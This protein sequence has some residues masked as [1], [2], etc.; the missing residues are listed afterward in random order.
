LALLIRIANISTTILKRIGDKWSPCQ[1]PFFVWKFWPTA[2]LIFIPTW[3]P[4]IKDA[5]HL[6][7]VGEK[8]FI[9]KVCYTKDQLILSYVFS[10]SI[11][12]MM[13]FYFFLCI[14]C[15]VSCNTITPSMM[16]LPGIKVVCDG[17]IVFC[18]IIVTLFVPTFV[19]ILKL[20]FNKHMCLYCWIFVDSLHLG[21]R[22]I[23]PKFRLYNGRSPWWNSVNRA[24][25]S[26]FIIFQQDW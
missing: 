1:T 15:M 4:S 7:H 18:A 6:R 16:F 23:V 2:S 3:P 10:K 14:S 25:R 26:S 12:N 21:S 17:L 13:P 5:T 9:L 11:L 22:I 8:P 19:K 24:M 20:T